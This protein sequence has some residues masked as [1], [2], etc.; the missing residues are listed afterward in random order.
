MHNI[1][2]ETRFTARELLTKGWSADPKYIVSFASGEKRLLRLSPTGQLAFR[3]LEF[4]RMKQLYALGIPMSEPLELG[5]C[6]GGRR[7]GI[8][9]SWIE[10][11]DLEM[12]LPALSLRQQYDLGVESGRILKKIHSLPAPPDQEDWAVR[13]NRKVDRNIALYQD[14]G[15]QVEGV[16]HL[17][18]YIRVS[19]ELL[20]DRPQCVQHGD[21]HVGNMILTKDRQ[22]FII[23]FNRHDAGDPWEE[24]NRIVWSAQVSPAFATGQLHGYFDGEPPSQFFALLAFYI[25]S[26]SL[27]SIPWAIS[28]GPKEVEGMIH[29][30]QKVLT[31]FD[32]MKNP[33]P[34]WYLDAAKKIGSTGEIL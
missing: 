25:A 27:S 9:L 29:Q 22:L 24:F 15:I 7:I 30:V 14:C 33:I 17:L 32:N 8:L 20:N 18:D 26:N 21:Y 1:I 11:D 10:G 23:D 5:Y 3:E 31:W 4:Q 34:N 16:Q 28:F 2:D 19:R 6:E 13:F 12:V